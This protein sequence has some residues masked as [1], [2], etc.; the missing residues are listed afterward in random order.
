MDSGIYSFRNVYEFDPHEKPKWE[1]EGT[2]ET[3]D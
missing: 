3:D 1:E 2:I